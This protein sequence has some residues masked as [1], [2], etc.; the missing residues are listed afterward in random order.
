MAMTYVVGLGLGPCGL[1]LA[2]ALAAGRG[3]GAA[4]AEDRFPISS[5][6]G[7][8]TMPIRTVSRNV[9]APHSR[10]T[11][12]QLNGLRVYPPQSSSE[13]ACSSFVFR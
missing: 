7:T 2:G 12:D 5:A 6:S 10:R 8:A 1:G 11:K 3:T 4:G 9:T 13:A